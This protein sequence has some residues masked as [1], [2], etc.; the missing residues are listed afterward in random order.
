MAKKTNTKI[1]KQGQI[2]TPAYIVKDILDRVGFVGKNCLKIRIMEPS[3]GNGAFVI[4]ILDRMITYAL[5]NNIDIDTLNTAVQ[6]N[7]YGIEKDPALH[8]ETVMRI[9]DLYDRRGVKLFLPHLVLGDALVESVRFVEQFDIVVGNPPYVRIQNIDEETRTLLQDYQFCRGNTDLYVAFYEIGLKML[10]SHGTLGYISPNSF[11]YNCSQKDF[12]ACLLDNKLI[13]SIHDFK[14]HMVFDNATTYTCICVLGKGAQSKSFS[15]SEGKDLSSPKEIFGFDS[16][17]DLFGCGSWHLSA[18]G[19]QFLRTQRKKPKQLS[20][21]CTIQNGV[22]TNADSIYIGKAYCDKEQTVPYLGKHA[23]PRKAVYFNGAEIE[24]D[25]LHRCAKASKHNGTLDNTYI[26]FPYLETGE[27]YIPMKEL[28][29]QTFFP[30]AYHYLS[31]HRVDLEKRDMEKDVAWF[32]FAR[33]QGL[34][35]MNKPKLVFKHIIPEDASSISV[36]CLPEDVVVYGGLFVTAN[37]ADNFNNAKTLL[38]SAD[39][40]SW[41]KIVGTSKHGE[42]VS[43]GSKEAKNFRFS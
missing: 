8:K 31:T 29:L 12:R 24:S 21:I 15:Y 4:E 35:N 7:V 3:F 41:C 19:M 23:D 10:K 37:N 1:K 16:I 33:S 27:G 34:T 32:L 26:L 40:A 6:E 36:D 2:F 39:F 25:I 22:A 18:D 17:R 11:L 42:Y 28:G 9:L 38:N 43:V 14:H 30:L 5:D 13:A 20:D